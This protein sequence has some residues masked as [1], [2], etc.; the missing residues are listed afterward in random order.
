MAGDKGQATGSGNQANYETVV[1]DFLNREMAT[2][3]LTQNVKSQSDEL[4]ALVSDLLKQV[5]TESDQPQIAGKPAPSVF[6]A[7]QLELKLPRKDSSLPTE[8]LTPKNEFDAAEDREQMLARFMP[9]PDLFSD[10]QTDSSAIQAES[11]FKS[12]EEG[13]DPL[14]EY[15]RL[16]EKQSAE[17]KDAP[18]DAVLNSSQ[19]EDMDDVLADYGM[20]EQEVSDTRTDA[21]AIDSG[22]HFGE[23]ADACTLTEESIPA[24]GEAAPAAIPPTPT[25]LQSTLGP[26]ENGDTST[27][28]FTDSPEG[29]TPATIEPKRFTQ[30]DDFP[31]TKASSDKSKP[32]IAAEAYALP[33]K[34]R[35]TPVFRAHP[36]PKPA[37]SFSAFTVTRKSK[38]P[39]IAVASL[40]VL[41]SIGIP[42]LHNSGKGK[43]AAGSRLSD[44]ASG[45]AIGSPIGPNG[46]IPAVPVRQVSPRYPDLA[47]KARESAVVVLELSINADGDV[48]KATPV[49]GSSLFHEEAVSAVMKW[50]Y[51][52]A[53]LD[54]ANIAS[55]S[56]VT[57]NFTLRN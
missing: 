46:E 41:A 1:L 39:W 27:A 20:P 44:A 36:T 4:D 49:S 9:P 26:A 10:S 19:F 54:G 43:Q 22:E 34:A 6:R 28:D 31:A 25:D 50:H 52:P 3:Q 16:Q 33:A 38:A 12:F 29:K 57:L 53:S 5:I 45:S 30:T 56:R 55:K 32:L 17:E 18:F 24:A 51:K 40:C 21:I 47:I 7:P 42:A 13:S 37:L 2:V 11:E 23:W 14:S 35:V 48:V 15:M 8:G